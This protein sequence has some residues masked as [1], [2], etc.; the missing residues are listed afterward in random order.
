V[1]PYHI[2]LQL[3]AVWDQQTVPVKL[4][5]NLADSDARAILV[6]AT[7]GRF[8]PVQLAFAW[9]RN[10]HVPIILGQVNFFLEFDVSFYR[11]QSAFE[12]RPKGV[13]VP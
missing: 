8:P 11:S 2:G 6:I 3:G 9:T 7:I 1:L 4:A 12:V 13:N 10:D 5:G